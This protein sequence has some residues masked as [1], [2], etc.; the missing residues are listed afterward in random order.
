[1]KLDSNCLPARQRGAVLFVALIFLLLIT[2]LALTAI[3]TSILQEKMTGGMRNQQLGMMGAESGLRGTEAWLWNLSFMGSQPL[4]PCVESGTGT[5]VYRPNLDG[6]LPTAVQKFRTSK[7]WTSAL[8]G[9]PS[10]AGTL[11][12]LGGDRE[13]ASLATQPV[14]LVEDLG[15][16][17]PPGAG[18]QSG[19]IDDERRGGPGTAW[20]YRITSRSYG[21]SAAVLNATESVFSSV[22]LTNTGIEP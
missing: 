6:T 16:N 14:V 13:T 3:G 1:M 11:T 8:P 19:A 22:N 21:G 9:T 15:P 12:G 10:Y 5:C 7:S 4:P 17:V 20:F 2:L 18:S